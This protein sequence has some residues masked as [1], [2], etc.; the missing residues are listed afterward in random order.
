VRTL[1][2]IRRQPL[3][4]LATCALLG[5][6][7]GCGDSD[8]QSQTSATGVDP[9]TSK[10]VAEHWPT[11]K[12]GAVVAVRDGEEPHC[13]A[14]G[15]AP[16]GCNTVY[17]IGS[18]TKGFTAAAIVKLA[19]D[20]ALRL[21]DRIGAYLDGVPPDKREITIRDLLTHTAGLPA[22]LGDD[23][24]PLQRDEMVS[25]AM[26]AQL[27]SEPGAEHR[28]SNVGYSLLAAI[29]EAAGGTSYEEYLARELF[30]PA[31]MEHTGYVLPD[32]DE[33]A[34]A[35]EFDA[36]GMDQ[37]TPLDHPWADDGPYWNL[38]GNGGLLSTPDDMARWLTALDGEAVL[39]EAEKAELW[40]PRVREVPGGS[41]RYAFGWVISP[42]P[43]GRLAWH[44][45]SNDLSFAVIAR[46]L[47]RGAGVFA[48]SNDAYAGHGSDLPDR[49]S[50]LVLG[51]ASA[52]DG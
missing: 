1:V 46:F 10:A 16:A 22:A 50:D 52:P 4:L 15:D 39:D 2:G 12:S 24:D 48:I 17:D 19:G 37:G 35:H 42:S 44:D 33:A 51:V 40:T 3:R 21:D 25:R 14:L 7:G 32:W 29:V 6:A 5:L 36:R 34:I 31:G 49:A 11:G 9:A 45:G 27:R 47:E 18:V 20:G 13:E 23:Y 38:R 26:A 43:L 28:Y 8:A 41:S 30:A